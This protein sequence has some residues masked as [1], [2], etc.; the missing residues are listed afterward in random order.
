VECS[1]CRNFGE[2]SI[3]GRLLYVGDDNWVHLNCALFQ[4]NT[5]ESF[6]GNL[7]NFYLLK[8]QDKVCSVCNFNNP[9]LACFK[10]K[11]FF[12]FPCAYN[13]KCHF[14]SS[15]KLV[16]NNCEIEIVNQQLEVLNDFS[17]R[18]KVFISQS[19]AS[20]YSKKYHRLGNTIILGSQ[21]T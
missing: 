8:Y 13:V 11:L 18:R 6:E 15:K 4:E 12:H 20:S 3:S 16:C 9:S 1:L 10:C 17:C 21:C 14:L 5:K 7:E 19:D 2:W